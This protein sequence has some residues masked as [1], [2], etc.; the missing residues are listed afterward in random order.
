MVT[1]DYTFS[2]GKG[3]D[4]ISLTNVL[5][6]RKNDP[7]QLE[8]HFYDPE[9]AQIKDSLKQL[10]YS[11]MEKYNDQ[12][13]GVDEFM[14]IRPEETWMYNYKKTPYELFGENNQKTKKQ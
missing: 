8:N 4:S 7:N 3:V 11:W 13:Y 9:Y 6:D 10:T 12:F 5:F 2:M 14:G 1:K